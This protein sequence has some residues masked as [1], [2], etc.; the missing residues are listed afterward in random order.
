MDSAWDSEAVYRAISAA[1]AEA[2][3]N[4]VKQKIPIGLNKSTSNLFR[5]RTSG[6]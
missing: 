5:E 4:A 6:P 1:L 2:V 3:Q